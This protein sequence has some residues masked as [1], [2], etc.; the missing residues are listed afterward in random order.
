V[1]TFFRAHPLPSGERVLRQTLER[2]DWYRG[3]RREAAAGLAA[4]LSPVRAGLPPA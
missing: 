1:A 3:F 2:F 4:R